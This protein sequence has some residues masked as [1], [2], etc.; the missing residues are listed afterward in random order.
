MET[1]ELPAFDINHH[2]YVAQQIQTG[3][4]H[5]HMVESSQEMLLAEV[6][7]LTFLISPAK[8][9]QPAMG[10]PVEAYNLGPSVEVLAKQP[11][12]AA[13]VVEYRGIRSES[14]ESAA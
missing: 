6:E 12:N 8:L 3:R 14:T 10:E 13:V 5:H 7:R 1:H 2:R 4:A 11:R 9:K